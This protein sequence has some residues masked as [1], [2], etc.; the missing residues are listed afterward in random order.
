[1]P[2]S[3]A[4][5]RG[6]QPPASDKSSLAY[7]I[8][9]GGRFQF[10]N[11]AMMDAP[12]ADLTVTKNGPNTSTADSDVTYTIEVTNL[13]PD[14][15]SSVALNDALPS[16]TTFH[17]LTP[18]NGWSCSDPGAGNNGTVTCTKSTFTANANAVFTLVV[19]V[20]QNATPNQNNPF[21]TN[22]ATVASNTND[23]N[24]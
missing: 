20:P 11:L 16:P 1:L 15:A 14:D 24:P 19:D 6:A 2:G 10:A 22:E 8:A 18:P 13:G 7:Q 4:K 17:S 21:I 23:P 3:S 5:R 9:G 12:V